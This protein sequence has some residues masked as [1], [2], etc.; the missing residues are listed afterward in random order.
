MDDFEFNFDPEERFVNFLKMCRDE[1]GEYIYRNK[2]AKLPTSGE[3]SLYV[4]FDDLLRFDPELA[5]KTIAEPD[6]MI[7]IGDIALREVLK[8]HDEDY[9]ENT[10]NLHLRF[11]NVETYV[12]LRQIRANHIGKL[13]RVEG[14]LMRASQVKPLLVT[15]VFQCGH[16]GEKIRIPQ[17][18]GRY[19]PPM[20]CPNPACRKKGP[21]KLIIEESEF[22]DWQKIRIQETPDELPPGQMPRS[23]DVIF[24][25]DLVDTCRPGDLVRIVGILRSAPDFSGAKK[26]AT[27]HVF[28]EANGVDVSEKE[29]EHLQISEEDEKKIIELS[30]DPFVHTKITQSLAPSI[31]GNEKI[32]EAVTLMLFGGVPKVLPD[33]TKIR[34]K[35]NI[36]L[37]GDPGTG[38]SQLLK[39]VATLATRG[40]YTSGKGTSAA[41]LTAAVVHDSETGAMTLEAG[42]LVLADQGVACIDEFDKMEASDRSAIHE[43][44]EQHTVSI[45]K[46]GIVATLNA[47]T[48][49]LAA[50]NPIMGRY[51][52]N[53]T[54]AENLKL[55]VTIL[56]R[57]DLIFIMID[58]PD[59]KKD[60][61]LARH[62]LGLHKTKGKELPPVLPPE[63]LRKY[64]AYATKNVKP[65]ISA[66]AAEEIE[67]F[68]IKMRSS[69]EAEGSPVPITAR[70][71]EAVI[72]LAEAR[73]RMALRDE[74]TREDAQAVIDLVTESL[75]AVGIDPETGQFDI[76][77]IYT[78]RSKSQRDKTQQIVEII[79]QLQLELDGPV[80]IDQIVDKAVNEGIDKDFVIRSI[81]QLKLDGMFYEPR[82]GYI[83][84]A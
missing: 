7:K 69:G 11:R 1:R 61:E 36:L 64:I 56:S 48:S 28:I 24:T 29:F 80:P 52:P 65:V 78:G 2:I 22:I 40:L 27:F 12:P 58:K 43:A 13:I 57:F 59:T 76:D 67:N 14:I 62:I 6:S 45:A 44:M 77:T 66:E 82:P 8:I 10:Q 71:L 49:I 19:T 18:E 21:F 26:L 75:K 79:E 73:A 37:V 41:G 33:G 46:A 9:A 5:R 32:K 4:D 35:S 38:K 72:R 51:N 83:S 47:R 16:C 55:P 81:D 70:Q 60:R 23:L 54:V 74:V 39:Y 17:E 15:G 63:F 31:H 84:K 42:A 34:G 25:D 20:V 3:I 50:A 68:Y 53:L 30:K